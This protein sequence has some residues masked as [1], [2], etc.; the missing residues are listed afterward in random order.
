MSLTRRAIL[1]RGLLA[2]AI[3]WI[4]LA[5]SA[6][7]GAALSFAWR[8]TFPNP[9]QFLQTH[10]LSGEFPISQ[11]ASGPRLPGDGEG[12]RTRLGRV[13]LTGTYVARRPMDPRRLV[14]LP[15]TPLVAE[16]W[17]LKITSIKTEGG[18]PGADTAAWRKLVIEALVAGGNFGKPPPSFSAAGDKTIVVRHPLAALPLGFE[19]LARKPRW[20]AGV[21]GGSLL[22]AAL[23]ARL[24]TRRLRRKLVGLCP[25]CGYDLAGLKGGACPECGGALA[26]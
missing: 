7:S 10:K 20:I 17:S 18:P 11:T 23:A 25:V 12:D 8:A 5:A 16:E 21:V 22:V 15:N 19:D 6:G 14:R 1:V 26:A 2:G 4:L 9:Q 3:L 24:I 13:A